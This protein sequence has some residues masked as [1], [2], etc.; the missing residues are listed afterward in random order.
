[1]ALVLGEDAFGLKKTTKNE[2]LVTNPFVSEAQRKAC[3]AKADPA[4]LRG[5]LDQIFLEL[6]RR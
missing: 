1:M 5:I 6:E 3:Y 4:E 2:E